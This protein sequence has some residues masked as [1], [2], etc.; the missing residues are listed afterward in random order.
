MKLLSLENCTFVLDVSFSK[1]DMGMA[2]L[3]SERKKLEVSAPKTES[4][5]NAM[6]RDRESPPRKKKHNTSSMVATV[7]NIHSGKVKKVVRKGTTKE[8]KRH[9]ES[10]LISCQTN[11]GRIG[12]APAAYER[13]KQDKLRQLLLF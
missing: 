12:A 4:I 6:E 11:V 3:N 1:F 13:R 7:P 5:I 10:V 9:S 2:L 8:V